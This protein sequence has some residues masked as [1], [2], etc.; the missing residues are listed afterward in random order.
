MNFLEQKGIETR[1]VMAGNIA[2][3][4][5]MKLFKYRKAG[6]LNNSKIIMR[7]SFFFGNHHGIGKV[8]REYIAD[9]IE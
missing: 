3:Q 4:P 7:N 6:E 1:P 5:A 9:C 2:E 8:E